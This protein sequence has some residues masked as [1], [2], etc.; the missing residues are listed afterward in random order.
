ML[1]GLGEPDEVREATEGY[2]AEMDVLAF[3]FEGCCVVSPGT[4]VRAT[5][6]YHAY[7]AWCA[8]A[9]ERS[10]N[11]RSFGMRL[12]ERG[13]VRKTIKG[14]TWY[15]GIG[16]RDDRPDPDGGVEEGRGT[17]SSQNTSKRPDFGKKVDEGRPKNGINGS[18]KA[19]EE[20]MPK[21]GLPPLHGLPDG[22]DACPELAAF[23]QDPPRWWLRQAAH[24]AG[25]GY[26]VGSIKALA[27]NTS[28]QLYGTHERW[29]EVLEAVQSWLEGEA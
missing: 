15:E 21:I 18:E 20:V 4:K 5:P 29:G 16:L 8:Q 7:R 12:T 13:F 9:G 3:F 28:T 10:E 14:V 2:R 1:E 26:P 6:L 22:D 27:R 24:I 17:P 25:E 11:Q 23:L 19:H